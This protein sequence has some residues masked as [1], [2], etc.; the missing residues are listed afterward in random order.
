MPG[1]NI[2]IE[3]VITSNAGE[4]I[5]SVWDGE[6]FALVHKSHAAKK[7]KTII[8]NPKEMLDLTKFG[9]SMLHAHYRKSRLE[10]L[11][12]REYKKRSNRGEGGDTPKR[13]A[14]LHKKSLLPQDEP[15]TNPDS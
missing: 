5:K 14:L 4:E 13:P 8:L 6:R 2:R 11:H 15:V 12:R 1:V 9:R 7:S 10:E 3:K